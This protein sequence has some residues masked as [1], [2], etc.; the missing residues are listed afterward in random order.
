MV[1]LVRR[2][3]FIL[4]IL[5]TSIGV[6]GQEQTATRKLLLP[7]MDVF[8]HHWEIGA[9]VGA[10]YD[11]GE[12]K[13][14]H[15]IS[16]TVQLSGAYHFNEYFALGL[17]VSGWVSKNEYSFPSKKYTWNFIQPVVEARLDLATL[18]RG[19]RPSDFFRPYLLLGAGAN[20]AFNNKDAENASE[21]DR[22]IIFQKLWTGTKV[23]PVFHGAVGADFWVSEKVALCLQVN[24]NVMSD[25]YNS[26][27]GRNDNWDW[28]FNALAGVRVRLGKANRHTDPVYENV[29]VPT[30]TPQPQPRKI[31]RDMADMVM[32][33]LFLINQSVIRDS[34]LVKLSEL[35]I[36]MQNHPESHILLTGYA[37][38]DTGTPAI[39]ERLSR[40]RSEVVAEWLKAHGI[41]EERLH[42]DHKGD[43]IQP[44]DFPAANRVTICI[45]LKGIYVQ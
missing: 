32:N 15:L 18:V 7:S 41:S 9:G 6:M 40:E 10:G 35:L 38:R 26:K 16:P 21:E 31:T 2:T 4:S 13:F 24:A 25:T 34:E 3:A 1:H 30:P 8:N 19:W 20:I 12:A 29:A 5:C 33:I 28:R 45:V 27:R 42:L 11:L 43:R 17:G 39:N 22:W 14:G 44:F 37:D 36:Y 23:L